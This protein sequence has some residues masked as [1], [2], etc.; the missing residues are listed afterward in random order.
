[1]LKEKVSV[2]LTVG[3]K[4]QKELC[5]K[6]LSTMSSIRFLDISV[7]SD[8]E[9]GRRVGSGGAVL[10]ILRRH[11]KSGDK[12]IIVNSGGM[13]KRSVNYAVRSKAFANALY[14]GEAVSLLELILTNAEK[15]IAGVN[16]G[17]LI[18]CSDIVVRTE[19]LEFSL[20]DNTGI[21]IKTDYLTASRHG[22]MVC[23]D[24][25]KMTD[26]LHKRSPLFLEAVAKKLDLC[27]M[28]VDTGITYFTDEFSTAL[29]E[30][31]KSDEF[32][33]LFFRGISEV[34]LYS[35]IIALLGKY[36]DK[37]SYLETETA[38]DNHR[39]IK[40][41]L[42][43]KL[44]SYTMNAFEV[45]DENFL[46]FGSVN[47][48][49]ENIKEISDQNEKN[50]KINS[51]VDEKSYVG[52]GTVLDGVQLNGCRIGE[53]CLVT[54]I[55]LEN[56]VVE[57]KKSVCGIKLCDGSFVTVICNINENPKDVVGNIS[58]WDLPRFYKGKSFTESLGKYYN[59]ADEQKYSMQE[60]LD[61]ADFDYYH[62]RRQYLAGL[63]SYTVSDSYLQKREEI[64]DCFFS[65]RKPLKEILCHRDK[66]EIRLPLR[67]NLSGTWTDAMPYCV[68]NGGQVINMAVTLDGELPVRVTVERL[69]SLAVEFCSDGNVIQF[70]NNYKN[71][72]DISDFNLHKAALKTIGI[73]SETVL[74]NGFR[75]TTQVTDVDKGSGLGTSSILLGGC[76]MALSRM[77][78]ISFDEG[79]IL[80]AVFVA[81]QIMNTGGGWQDQVGGLTPG[82]KSG[83]TV[84][85]TEQY[86][87]VDY[88]DLP[89]SFIKMFSER[90]ILMPSG[91][92]HFGRF[93]V[94]DVVNRYLSGNEESVQG[95]KDI[96]ELDDKLIRSI[97]QEDEKAFCKVINEH[98]HLLQKISPKV[99]NPALDEIMDV[100]LQVAYAV[101]PCGAG[102]G[103]YLLVVL[104][105][106]VSTEQFK[107]FAKEKFPWIKSSVKKIDIYNHYPTFESD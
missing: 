92:R 4:N 63:D 101:S 64:L 79:E 57:A 37:K 104:K 27:G 41:L 96:R 17:V 35:D 73:N 9:L 76:I 90:L 86:L 45:K 65:S 48:A 25:T 31:S 105:E 56:S 67:V 8:D 23:D 20:T 71:E 98:R 26:Y 34:G 15:I 7:V 46:H 5:E 93:I 29:T 42:F 49:V 78:E 97:Q 10:N 58:K 12:M 36:T 61:N 18:C 83:T 3:N 55:T 91:Q 13:S 1:M 30:L 89:E 81:E 60:C 74:R 87:K 85:G 53:G 100:C 24:K 16:S 69:D 22:V 72:E 82:I 99:T 106:N 68:D 40:E 54:D 6:L 107:A 11:Y 75:L 94:N 47:E 51:F 59:Q 103:G 33:K 44:S 66:V 14:K 80:R 21:C 38:D 52:D 19:N 84:S 70:N 32:E 39:R 88:I 77:F 2:F 28:L 95:H 62:T 43:D 50:I 102:G